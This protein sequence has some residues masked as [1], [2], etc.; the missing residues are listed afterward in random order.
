MSDPDQRHA[1]EALAHLE[2][3][4]VQEIFLTETAYHADVITFRLQRRPCRGWAA[5]QPLRAPCS[6]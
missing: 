3:L 2:H 1:R 6:G 5:I 4:V